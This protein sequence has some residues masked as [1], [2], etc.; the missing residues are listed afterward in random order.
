[1][2]KTI[3]IEFTTSQLSPQ[4][5]EYLIRMVE[6]ELGRK[7]I[8]KGDSKSLLEYQNIYVRTET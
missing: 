8:T 5:D 7:G 2:K 6:K 1:M 3:I 4:T